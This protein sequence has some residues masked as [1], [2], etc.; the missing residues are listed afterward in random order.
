MNNFL[1]EKNNTDGIRLPDSKAIRDSRGYYWDIKTEICVFKWTFPVY[2]RAGGV[3][4]F[5]FMEDDIYD[6]VTCTHLVLKT[7]GKTCYTVELCDNTPYST[8]DGNLGEDWIKCDVK[9]ELGI[10]LYNITPVRTSFP[11]FS[12]AL[13]PVTL[14]DIL[15]VPKDKQLKKGYKATTVKA[16]VLTD[17]GWR[18]KLSHNSAY[19]TSVNTEGKN[20]VRTEKEAEELFGENPCESSDDVL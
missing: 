1:I 8:S 11:E 19:E 13:P 4:N 20:W 7:E 10:D 17:K 16:L 6:N 3:Y 5:T 15:Y 9:E 12:V 2:L 18:M 14:N